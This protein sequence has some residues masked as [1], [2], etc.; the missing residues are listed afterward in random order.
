MTMLQLAG[1]PAAT[2]FRLEKLRA[3]LRALASAVTDVAAHFEHF[4]HLERPLTEREDRVLRALLDYGGGAAAAN[5]RPAKALR[6]AAAR[7]DLVVGLEGHRYREDLL[8][9]GAQDRARPRLRARRALRAHGCRPA[10]HRAAAARSNDGDAA[11]GAAARRAAVRRACAAARAHRRRARGRACRARA[12]QRRVRPRAVARRD[13]LSRGAVRGAE[14]QSD[15]RRAHDVRAGELGALPAQDLQ[16]GLGHRRRACAEE[17]VRDDPQHARALAAK[18]CC[19]RTRTTPPSSR[20]RKLAGSGPMPRRTST[21]TRKSRRISRSRSRRTTIRRRSRRIPGAATGSGGEIRDEGATGRGAKPKAGLVGFTVSH[22]ELPGWRQPWERSSPGKPDRIASPLAIML[23]GPIGAASFNNEFGRP[24]L[25]G[26]FRTSLIEANGVWR[27]YHKP[28][29][30]A[31]GLGNVRA[32]NVDE[33]H[34]G[35]R[36]QARRARRPGDADR[37]RRRRGVVARQRRG[38]GRARLRLRAARQRRDAAA[39][40]RGHRH[41]LGAR[42]AQS[43]RRDSRHRRGRPF[44]RR[45]RDRRPQRLRRRDRPARHSERRARHEPDGALVQRIARALHADD[46]GRRLAALR[47]DLRARARAVRRHRRADGEPRARRAR[48]DTRRH[49]RCD[50]D[51]SAVRQAAEDDAASRAHA[52]SSPPSGGAIS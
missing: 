21:R 15:R 12:R 32:M 5:G 1:P 11:G 4:V 3:E 47:G 28:I 46:R 48:R 34:A 17:P 43:D 14:A 26:Y 35:P 13:R 20:A 31:G 52:R 45:A 50:A 29:M 23:D 44:E 38:R 36:R 18:A 19:R 30:I 24:N 10:A 41:V 6:R 42:R 9:S 51:G 7:H 49:A 25:A 22:L 8:A 27:G 16:R 33:G 39:R 37:A 2:A 40:A